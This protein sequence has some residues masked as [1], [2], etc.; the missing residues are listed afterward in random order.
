MELLGLL[1]DFHFLKS[2]HPPP[3]PTLSTERE[4]NDRRR[5]Q[6]NPALNPI[7]VGTGEI[8]PT[9]TPKSI[10]SCQAPSESSLNSHPDSPSNHLLESHRNSSSKNFL[11]LS[12][13]GS[14]RGASASSLKFPGRDSLNAFGACQTAR[15]S[16]E[17]GLTENPIC[18]PCETQASGL[19]DKEQQISVPGRVEDLPMLSVSTLMLLWFAIACR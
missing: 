18:V 6:K 15:T 17:I 12:T 19:T 3:L 4:R 5:Q 11:S 2:I 9:V 10:S 13:N 1:D 16:L 8:D 14:P 7:K